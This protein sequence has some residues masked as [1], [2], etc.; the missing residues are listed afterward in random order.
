V[1]L[2]E[3]V[4]DLAAEVEESKVEAIDKEDN[5]ENVNKEGRAFR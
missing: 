5:G 3:T 1:L 2:V 4:I